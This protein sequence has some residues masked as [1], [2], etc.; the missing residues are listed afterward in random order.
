MDSKYRNLSVN[1]SFMWTVIHGTNRAQGTVCTLDKISNVTSIQIFP[2]YI[3]YETT[4]DNVYKKISISIEEFTSITVLLGTGERYHMLFD[5][6]VE[7]NRIKLVQSHLTSGTYVFN[8]P[9]NVLDTIS[10][11]IQITNRT[12]DI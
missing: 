4:A 7:S 3:P 10:L 9:I 6:Q 11:K 2:F 1:D 12:C 5:S 8:T